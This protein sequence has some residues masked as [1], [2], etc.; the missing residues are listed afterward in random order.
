MVQRI[1]PGFIVVD[2]SQD[3]YL[4]SSDTHTQVW[5]DMSV[6]A[7]DST[8]LRSDSTAVFA[9]AT[10]QTSGEG[11]Q[12]SATANAKFL[13]ES[14]AQVPNYRLELQDKGYFANDYVEANYAE[15]LV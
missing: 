1:Q 5:Y 9:D 4:P 2:G 14:Q 6:S 3:Q 11:L 7:A 15:D 13:L 10:G 12:E 8:V